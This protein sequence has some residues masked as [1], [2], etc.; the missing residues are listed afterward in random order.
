MNGVRALV[1]VGIKR[2]ENAKRERKEWPLRGE[3]RVSRPPRQT[4]GSVYA[5]CLGHKVGARVLQTVCSIFRKLSLLFP[6]GKCLSLFGRNINGTEGFVRVMEFHAN[7]SAESL[8]MWER[9][10]SDFSSSIEV[11]ENWVNF[12]NVCLT[13]GL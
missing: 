8:Y 5:K 4:N 9:T 1:Y 13:R 12:L 10:R 11:E 7:C 6:R 2:R 3:K